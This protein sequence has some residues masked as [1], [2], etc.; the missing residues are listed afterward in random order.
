MA[1]TPR[2]YHLESNAEMG[3]GGLEEEGSKKTS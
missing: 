2:A 3:G 1:P